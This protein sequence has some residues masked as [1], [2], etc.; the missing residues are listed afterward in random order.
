M[1]STCIRFCDIPSTLD[2]R[3]TAPAVEVV[4]LDELAE[5]ARVESDDE[6]RTMLGHIASAR[7]WVENEVNLCLGERTL[8]LYLDCFPS[9]EIELRMPPV[10]TLTSIVYLDSA[11]DSQT[12]SS[13]LYRTDLVSRPCRITP[14]YG[15]YWPCTY[16]VTKAITIAMAAGYS[17][18][19][20]PEPAKEVIKYMA[21]L[22]ISECAPTDD[23]L[24]FARRLLD[25][26]RW[27]GDV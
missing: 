11:G 13:S 3:L 23:Q 18:E 2:G 21:G 14:A 20:A 17:A 4:S 27:T 24:R 1:T 6:A 7:A 8:T 22:Y 16:P 25:P 9:W 12:L 26:I 5:Y 10:T 19:T 15:Q